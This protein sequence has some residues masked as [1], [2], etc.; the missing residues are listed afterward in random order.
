MSGENTWKFIA[1]VNLILL[2]FF[3]SLSFLWYASGSACDEYTPLYY[4]NNENN[5]IL[6]TIYPNKCDWGSGSTSAAVSTVLFFITGIAMLII[7]AP[8]YDPPSPPEI[9]QVTYQ[10]TE[11]LDGTYTVQEV[12]VVKGTEIQETAMSPGIGTEA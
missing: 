12:N 10:K 8:K 7:G 4:N 6:E 9:R 1:I 11:N 3:Q 2:T 5:E